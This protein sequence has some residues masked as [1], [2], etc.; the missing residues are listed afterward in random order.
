MIKLTTENN[1][2]NAKS[3]AK[4]NLKVTL[5]LALP[6][7]KKNTFPFSKGMIQNKAKL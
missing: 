7:D 5:F 2:V 4:I 3:K 1:N 6:S